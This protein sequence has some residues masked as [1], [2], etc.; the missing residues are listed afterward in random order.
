MT[1]NEF[2]DDLRDRAAENIAKMIGVAP[3]RFTTPEQHFRMPTIR[4]QSASI[5]RL[6]SHHAPAHPMTKRQV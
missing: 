5:L 1:R 4:S 2:C 6:R 3:F